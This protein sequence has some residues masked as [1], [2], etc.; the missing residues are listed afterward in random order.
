VLH[1]LQDE[2]IVY[3][4][5]LEQMLTVWRSSKS[6]CDV[7][8]MTP[9]CGLDEQGGSSGGGEAVSRQVSP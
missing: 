3:R 7:T 4:E 5:S 6:W 8:S 2:P 1:I 9:N